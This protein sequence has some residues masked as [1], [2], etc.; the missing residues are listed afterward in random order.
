MADALGGLLEVA[1]K[2]AHGFAL[3]GSP[4][5]RAG[6]QVQLQINEQQ[7]TKQIDQLNMYMSI[8]KDRTG[9]WS[10]EAQKAAGDS[11]RRLPIFKNIS[12]RLGGGQLRGEGGAFGGMDLQGLKRT[13][14]KVNPVT[15]NIEYAFGEDIETKTQMQAQEMERLEKKREVG[16][17]TKDETELLH[18]MY[19]G[20]LVSIETG[21]GLLSPKKREDIAQAEYEAKTTR[22][23]LTVTEQKGV[24]S[25]VK[26]ILGESK[27]LPFGLRRGAA[28]TQEDMNRKWENTME[29]TGYTGRN[30][31]QQ[32]QI[33]NE[34]DRQV[35]VL[36]KGKGVGVLAN[37]YQWD[38]KK[39]KAFNKMKLSDIP[40]PADKRGFINKLREL[41]NIDPALSA[42]YYNKYLDKFW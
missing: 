3:V 5:Y 17:I 39:Y 35:G 31:V 1:G 12:E 23:P 15:G 24:N 19:S 7:R 36:N 32:K 30:E 28:V 37:Q 4:G 22:K 10:K 8:M 27:A 38:R 21:Q 6:Q 16:T 29:A 40:I 2:A 42:E 9:T 14:A 26:E 41:E 34:F 18:K 13:G 33:E 11:I 25:T 20:S